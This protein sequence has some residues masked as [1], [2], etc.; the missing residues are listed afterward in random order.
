VDNPTPRTGSRRARLQSRRRRREENAGRFFS[1]AALGTIIPG[2]GLLAAGRRGWGKF[3]LTLVGLGFVAAVAV[4]I[5]VPR[6]RLAAGAFDRTRLGLVAIGL[7]VLAI[8]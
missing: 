7:A 4:L 1:L 3:I 8:A 6:T 5:F 2:L